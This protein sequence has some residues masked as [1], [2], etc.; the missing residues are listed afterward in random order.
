MA[1]IM[2]ISVKYSETLNIINLSWMVTE[3]WHLSYIVSWL[4]MTVTVL[5]FKYSSDTTYCNLVKQNFHWNFLFPDCEITKV[6]LGSYHIQDYQ[7][8]SASTGIFV[9]DTFCPPWRGRIN[10]PQTLGNEQ[11]QHTAQKTPSPWLQVI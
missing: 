1:A 4:S 3:I 2:K 9:F 6:G 8:T 11:G 10:Q 5:H 7:M